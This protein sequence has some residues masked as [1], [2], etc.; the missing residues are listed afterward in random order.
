MPNTTNKAPYHFQCISGM[1]AGEIKRGT[2]LE[3]MARARVADGAAGAIVLS[4]T[5]CWACIE[6]AREKQR[7]GWDMMGCPEHW[8][9]GCECTPKPIP[10]SPYDKQVGRTYY[11]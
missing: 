8:D 9:N 3:D 4:S 7:R 1:H 11:Y 6:D 2:E 10:D 5:E